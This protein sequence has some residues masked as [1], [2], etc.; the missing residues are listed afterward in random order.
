MAELAASDAFDGLDYLPLAVGGCVLVAL[1]P[2]RRASIA[3]FAGRQQAVAQA[4]QAELPAPGRAAGPIVWAGFG[5]WFLAGPEAGA[6]AARMAGLAAVTDQSDA[7]SGLALS[8]PDAREAL[9]RLVPLDLDPATFPPGAAARSMLRHVALLLLATEAG[10]E[11]LVPR[12]YARTAV[13]DLD[14]AMRSVAARAA[15]RE[16]M[17]E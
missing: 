7:W 5:I 12:S 4:L 17:P 16:I 2:V 11:L 8:G 14:E 9:A 1:P 13:H 6:A 10:F 15:L 3:P